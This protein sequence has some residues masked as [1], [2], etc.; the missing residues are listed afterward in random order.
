MKFKKD[1]TM[2]RAILGGAFIIIALLGVFGLFGGNKDDKNPVSAIVPAEMSS[3]KLEA[4]MSTNGLRRVEF[5]GVS[6]DITVT[7]TNSNTITVKVT[8]NART[9][10]ELVSEKNGSVGTFEVKWPRSIINNARDM[11]MEV[12][13][14]ANYQDDVS[15]RSVSGDIHLTERS[16]FNDV[17]LN[18]VSGDIR[19]EETSSSSYSASTVSGD[20]SLSDIFSEDTSLSSISGDIDYTGSLVSL[21]A[22]SVSGDCNFSLDSL[23]GR[24]KLK[25]TSGDIELRLPE[26]ISANIDLSTVSGFLSSDIPI[27]T[28]GSKKNH[29]SGTIGSGNYSIEGHTVSGDIHISKN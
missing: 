1:K 9:T 25:S 17:T 12:F 5:A 15:F 29:L 8:G 26:S 23:T 28:T 11:K 10:P 22:S 19:N 4:D 7:R 6:S 16:T 2:N 21:T 27:L 18:T 20:L 14:P 24:I 3:I 13:L